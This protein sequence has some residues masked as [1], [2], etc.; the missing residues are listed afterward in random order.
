MRNHVARLWSGRTPLKRAFW[1]Y[2]IIYGTLLNLVTTFA[3][4][5][6]LTSGA[7]A[8]VALAIFLA[9]LPYNILVVVA[10][11]RSAAN[12]RGPAHWAKL[13]RIIVVVWA[14]IATVV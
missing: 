12:Y 7:H 2:A 13:A 6:A 5:M 9:P 4:L 10:V 1:D 3:A 8:A 14:L 11:W